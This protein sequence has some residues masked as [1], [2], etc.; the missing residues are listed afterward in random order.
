MSELTAKQAQ[1][2]KEYL[3][4]L[5]ATQ[6]AIRAGYAESGAA[7]EGCRLLTN[8]KVAEAIAALQAERSKR[9]EI[10][11]DWVLRRLAAIADA[12]LS[13]LYD[14]EG[15]L[16]PAKEWP[17]VWRKGLVAGVDVLEK[18]EVVDGE[19][20]RVGLVQ[21]VKLADRLKGL[22]LIGKHVA[23]QAFKENVGVTAQVVMIRPDDAGL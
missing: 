16:K 18:F 13:D 23:V 2:V 11:A 8:P 5:N 19:R 15:G 17:E 20:Q 7:V 3:I 10:D 6:A 4:D 12:D 1:F 22:E 21:K 14:A 9:T